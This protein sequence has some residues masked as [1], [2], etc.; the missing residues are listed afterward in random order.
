M[1]SLPLLL[2]RHRSGRRLP[3]V[4]PAGGSSPIGALGYVE[5][6][7]ELAA[8]VSAGDLPGPTH[9]VT[10]VGTG[11]TAAGL[12]LGLRLAGLPTRVVGVVVNNQL[13]LDAPTVLRLARRTERLLRRRGAELPALDLGDDDVV[14]LRDWLGDGYGH[15]TP[16]AEDA[17]ALAEE[18]AGL[19]LETVY[20]A[21]ALVA[22]RDMNAAERFGD[23][24]VVFLNT[25][26]P[27]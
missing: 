14:L 1:A 22:V 8:Q 27:R 7:F 5:A 10:A 6:A 11:G 4:L 2:W 17:R 15:P 9:V 3:Y 21:K 18:R 23:G 20:T 19:N 16:E 24:P 26:G 13:R 25:N 12:T